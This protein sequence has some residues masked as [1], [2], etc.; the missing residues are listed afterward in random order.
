MSREIYRSCRLQGLEIKVPFF[1]ESYAFPFELDSMVQETSPVPILIFNMIKH[2]C[3]LY[4]T[5][6]C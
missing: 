2:A 3:A 1:L 5:Q 6:M 4:R